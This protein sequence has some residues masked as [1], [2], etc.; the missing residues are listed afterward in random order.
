MASEPF[1][2]A[3]DFE[4][5]GRASHYACAIG[6]VRIENGAIA[7]TYYR[8]IRPPSSYVMFSHCHGLYW[9]DLK[10]EPTFANIWPEIEA[11][12]NGADYL[13]AHNARFDQRVLKGCCEFFEKPV[14]AAPFLDTLKG[15][16][17]RLSL[18]SY[19]LDS[20]CGHLN[21]PLDHHHALSDAYGCAAIYLRLRQMGCGLD[22]LLI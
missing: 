14:P 7:D 15:A 5:S 2:A 13:I 22:E 3:I 11:F 20:V 4:T 12:I 6:V 21:I 17:R 10:N 18:P 19:S 16:R 1:C 9:R 8:L